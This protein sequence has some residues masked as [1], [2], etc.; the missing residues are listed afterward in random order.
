VPERGSLLVKSLALAV[1]YA[2]VARA[3]LAMDAV[4]GLATLVWPPT[5]IALAAL[6]LSSSKLWPGVALGAFAANVW[7]GA[8]PL[9]ALG[10]AAGN[11]LEAVIGARLLL[12]ARSFR[13][14]L[15]DLRSVVALIM[16]AALGSTLVS[17]FAG[18]LAMVLARVVPVEHAAQT[19]Q[20]WWVGDVI[21][22]LVVAPLVLTFR[23]RDATGR[24][25][26]ASEA[27]CLFAL[28]ASVLVVVFGPAGE[29]GPVL[30]APHV[31]MPLL[32]WAAIRFGP[33]GAAAA[34]FLASSGA[35]AGTALGHGSFV[36][37]T[38]HD[39]LLELQSFMAVV[40]ITFLILAAVTAERRRLLERERVG[41]EDAERAVQ[42]REEF[43][44]IVSHELRTPLT[45]LEL[46]LEAVL[47]AVPA[48]AV[49]LRERVERAK[50]Q[51]GRLVKL[52]EAL[53]DSSRVASGQLELALESFDC[54][55]LVGEALDQAREEAAR[56]GSVL[57]VSAEGPTEGVWDRQRVGQ[58]I[59]NLLA[60]AI[61]YGRGAPIDI[62]LRGSERELR[63]S[64]T[65]RGIGIG[66]ASFASIFE[67]FERATSVRAHGGLGLGLY[68]AR[69]IAR[70]HGGDITVESVLGAGSTFTLRLPRG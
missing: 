5:G 45:P 52:V 70:A 34:T 3:G 54:E 14:A 41:R 18:T 17:A 58:A 23:V 1:V 13:P 12:R 8:A 15:D 36:R 50:R 2:L 35:V 57:T 19:F 48:D 49:G 30:R 39:G 38:L 62:W 63:I 6:L 56:A 68:V 11:T 69:Q 9:V 7:V 16:L 33:R 26:S 24:T 32:A 20:V 46:Q 67:R 44:A 21:G 47:R 4:G 53:L 55:K 60:N 61:R 31:L 43:L 10:I 65:D 28:L 37:G 25:G 40:A 51:S 59:S 64:C 66:S 27:L 29:F 22:A 42:R